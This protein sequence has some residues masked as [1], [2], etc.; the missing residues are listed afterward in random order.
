MSPAP[1][2]LQR[3]R[4]NSLILIGSNAGS[5]LLSFGLSVLIGRSLGQSGLGLYVAALAWIFPLSLL[6]E[7][8]LG[9][10]LTRE[11]ASNPALRPALL[12][13]S[14]IQRLLMGLPLAAIVWLIAPS[15]SQDPMLIEGIRISTPLI[16]IYPLYSSYTA[17]FRSAQVM[18]PI[19]WLNL[20]MLLAQLGL[21]FLV[22]SLGQGL[23]S[24][25]LVNT[26]TSLGQLMAAMLIY[27]L[28]FA[29]SG[30][31]QQALWP[32]LKQSLPFAL[33]ALIA[34]VQV[35]ISI[36]LLEQFTSSAEVGLY[37]AAARFIEGVHLISRGFFD[38]LFPAL[39]A[40]AAIPALLNSR[41]Q[42]YALALLGLAL[43]GAG[44][45]A[46]GADLL[47]SLTYGPD[48]VAAGD[49]L[50]L[51]S[52]S[53]IPGLLKSIIILYWFTRQQAM[54]VNRMNALALLLQFIAGYLLIPLYG[55]GGAAL[56]L[57]LAESCAMLGLWLPFYWRKPDQPEPQDQG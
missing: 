35:R 32:L 19:L 42:A 12:R 27:R 40:I 43:L 14:L 33:A 51:L 49:V 47:I 6:I 4:Q 31:A 22:L 17:I 20:G 37:A 9:T 45:S 41:I 2:I 48:F 13:A 15:L 38:A 56:S 21:S 25:L 30:E 39:A 55:A 11:G 44:A 7:F 57:I 5:A 23:I 34:A 46:I 53:L 8:G 3:L 36:I 10:L 26:L 24:L 52:L 16:L 54:R 1:K 50:R 28:G 29:Q 18:R